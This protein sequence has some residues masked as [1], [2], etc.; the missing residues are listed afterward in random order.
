MGF[1][2]VTCRQYDRVGSPSNLVGFAALGL[3]PPDHLVRWHKCAH[4]SLGG[5]IICRPPRAEQA[6]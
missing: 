3:M 2:Q 1:S 6:S 5:S 4:P